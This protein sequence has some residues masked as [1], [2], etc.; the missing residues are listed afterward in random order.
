[1]KYFI[2]NLFNMRAYPV[3]SDGARF[4]AMALAVLI[5]GPIAALILIFG[6]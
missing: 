2:K 6:K 4:Q 5:G 1:M 3:E